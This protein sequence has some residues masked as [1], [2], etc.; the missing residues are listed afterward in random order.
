MNENTQKH[1]F[2]PVFDENSRVLILGSFPPINTS[3]KNEFYYGGT[4]NVFWRVLGEVFKTPNLAEKSKDEKIA[5]LK[6][7]KIALYDIWELCCKKD[8]KS[9]SDK[10]IIAKDSRKVD[11]SEILKSAKIQKVFTTIDKGCFKTW[12]IED[13]L[14]DEYARYFPHCKS[15]GEI[16]VSLFS[17]SPRG[18]QT[19]QVSYE[20]IRDDYKKIA[21]ILTKG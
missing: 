20:Q 6:A 9:A 14:W 2:A 12:H 3:Q 17:T 19:K 10:G 15:K 8:P 11:L 16:V 4:S 13:W 18:I 1:P 21:E 7:H 5:F